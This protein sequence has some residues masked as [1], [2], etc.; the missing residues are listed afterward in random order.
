LPIENTVEREIRLLE[1]V[2]QPA[3]SRSGASPFSSKK[4]YDQHAP[5]GPS[6]IRL[7]RHVS[8]SLSAID[9]GAGLTGALPAKPCACFRGRPIPSGRPVRAK[10]FALSFAFAVL[11]GI[12]LEFQYCVD[13]EKFPTSPAA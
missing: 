7:H 10:I 4:F 11:I 5:L 8:L 6:A 9:D 13:W 12:P 2:L 3:D 1:D